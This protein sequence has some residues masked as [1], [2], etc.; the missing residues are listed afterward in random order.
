MSV[1]KNSLNLHGRGKYQKVLCGLKI[2][3]TT[4]AALVAEKYVGSDSRRYYDE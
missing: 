1:R 2:A 3:E 4:G